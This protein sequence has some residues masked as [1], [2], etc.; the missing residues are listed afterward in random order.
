MSAAGD[1][2]KVFVDSNILLYAV[3][4][5]IPKKRDSSLEWVEHLWS[6]NAGR[7]SW[8]VLAE[9]YLNA[10]RKLNVSREEARSVVRIYSEWNPIPPNTRMMER[11]WHWCDQ[12]QI[13]FWDALILAAAEQA[14][15][16]W[17]L[18]EDFQ[19][20]QIFDGITVVNPFAS[21]PGDFGLA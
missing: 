10:I 3:D 17:L 8:Q 11:A 19:V 6:R 13:N 12:S 15:C 5:R 16:R 7:I 9:F 21:S 2:D 20:G 18:S 4:R 14:G 1:R